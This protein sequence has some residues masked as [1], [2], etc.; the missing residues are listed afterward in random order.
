MKSF[1]PFVL[2][3]I[4]FFIFVQTVFSEVSIVSPATGYSKVWANKQ[5]LVVNTTDNEE[6]Y[7]SISDTDPLESGFVYDGP[8]LLDITGEVNLR[9]ASINKNKE[10]VDYVLKYSVKEVDC[11]SLPNSQESDFILQMNESPVKDLICGQ[12]LLIPS[13]L[14]YSISENGLKEKFYSGELIKL[15]EDSNLERFVSLTLK[16]DDE[17]YWNYVLHSIPK[18]SG[19]FSKAIVPFEINEW[20]DIVLKDSNFIYS[21]DDSDWWEKVGTTVKLD[22]TIPHVIKWQNVK[23]DK[24]NPINS[25]LIPAIPKIEA[26]I[27]ADSTIVLKL[28]GDQSY[29]FANGTS[30][31]SSVLLAS[32]MLKEIIVDAYK[33]ENFS[34]LIPVDIYSQNVFNG[35]LF[36]SVQVNRTIPNSPSIVLSSSSSFS[37]ED[38]EC[39]L[40]SNNLDD[41]IMYYV[42]GP[43]YPSVEEIENGFFT[44]DFSIDSNSY[45]VY[46]GKKILFNADIDKPA[47]YKIFAYSIDKW[48]NVSEVEVSDIYINKSDYFFDSNS[49]SVNSDGT[50]LNPY[51]DLSQI[52]NIVNSNSFSKIYLSG[53]FVLPNEKI[54]FRQNLKIVGSNSSEIL[55][56]EKSS[57]YLINSS[58]DFDNILVKKEYSNVAGE[59]SLLTIENSVLNINN[60]TFSYGSNKNSTLINSVKSFVKVNS[61]NLSSFSNNYACVISAYDSNVNVL[62]SSVASIANT[63]VN[64]SCRNSTLKLDDSTCNVTGFNGRIVELFSSNANLNNNTFVAKEIQKQNKNIP[65]WKDDLSS[66]SYRN[67]KVVGF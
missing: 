23:Y 31:N 17:T 29:R 46:N 37:R 15:S 64:F 1:K 61:S 25:Y 9:I 59:S 18:S 14:N 47:A 45:I 39:E 63:N 62:K 52:E 3:F 5:V 2:F 43:V 8:V 26:E 55:F 53:R 49:K 58:L 54:T 41:K 33:G 56:D 21:I 34:K 24:M 10:R 4:S 66:L 44:K 65:L 28:V 7:Y 22:R 12:E 60:S 13:T 35:K 32:G 50:Y 51:K 36:A 20:T 6:I 11:S 30:Q 19:E 42:H 57:L 27:Q 48:N 16:N 67:N 40:V 38:I